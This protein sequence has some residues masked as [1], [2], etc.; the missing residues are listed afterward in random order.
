M[1]QFEAIGRML[2]ARR[3][4]E[5]LEAAEEA[6]P[7]R[8]AK[9]AEV[10]EAAEAA[11]VHGAP[12]EPTPERPPNRSHRTAIIVG[13]AVAVLLV[14]GGGAV[15]L[16][17]HH[18]AAA[19]NVHTSASAASSTPTPGQVAAAQWV[20]DSVG[21]THVVACDV[22]VCALLVR[23]GLPTASVVTVGSAITDV[24]RADVVVTTAVIR[25]TFGTALTAVTSAEPLARFGSGSDLVEVTPVAL[26]G[27]E[28]YARQLVLDRAARSRVGAILAGSKRI[29][30]ANQADK[31]L[32]AD[33]SLDSR[34]CSL[35]ALISASHKI[36]VAAFGPAGP[37]AGADVGDT[38]VVI[39]GI[40]G[41]P[42]TGG[43]VP[44]KALLTLVN[45]QRP[46][47]QPMTVTSTA[48]GLKIVFPV[49]EP[50]GLIADS[51]P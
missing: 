34:V 23:G 5:R 17:T 4:A 37:G 26:T 15:A 22:N 16:T 10:A 51:T 20:L 8:A 21:P 2:E 49:P 40:D 28:D 38:T 45:A 13:T 19:G 46:P 36:T 44:A 27:T 18:P 7:A 3:E 11:Q 29:T 30:L 32:L 12:E 1:S 43:S 33:G 14:A 31:L 42:A 25:Q 9:V 39:S 6:E 47:Y 48:R 41:Q 24:E 35:L 50:L